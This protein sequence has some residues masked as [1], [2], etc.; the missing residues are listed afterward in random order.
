MKDAAFFSPPSCPFYTYPE[1]ENT[2]YGQQNRVILATLARDGG[3]H[4]VS[5]Q[6]SYYAF[7]GPVDAPCHDRR[8]CY[9]DGSTKGFVKNYEAGLRWPDVGANDTQGNALVHMVPIVAALAGNES[10]MLAAVEV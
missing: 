2:P 9:W 6:D 4:P 7:Y 10:K 3:L 5:M 1:G 8:G